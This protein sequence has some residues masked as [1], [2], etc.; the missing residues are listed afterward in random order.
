MVSSYGD[1]GYCGASPETGYLECALTNNPDMPEE[2]WQTVR[3]ICPVARHLRDI[4]PGT[5]IVKGAWTQRVPS[6]PHPLT[7]DEKDRLSRS[8]HPH[9]G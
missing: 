6:G 8:R 9:H 2:D 3:A 7:A 1:C 4:F 5:I